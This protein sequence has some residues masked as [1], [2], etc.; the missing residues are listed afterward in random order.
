MGIIGRELNRGRRHLVHGTRGVKMS[1][2]VKRALISSTENE[3]RFEGTHVKSAKSRSGSALAH[4]E[5]NGREPNLPERKPSVSP[6]AIRV[7]DSLD[8]WL[9][10][11]S[12]EHSGLLVKRPRHWNAQMHEIDQVASSGIFGKGGDSERMSRSIANG[13]TEQL[14]GRIDAAIEDLLDNRELVKLPHSLR[15]QIHEDARS[16]GSVVRALCPSSPTIEV[17][18]EM[19]GENACKRWHQDHYIGRALVSYSGVM[20][21]QYTD[22]SNVDFW[23]LQNCGNNKCIIRDTDAV[24]SVEVGDILFIKGKSFPKGA[25]ALVHKAAELHYHEDG[26]IVNRLA[27]KVDVAA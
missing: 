8:D 21:T 14:L 24:R 4:L 22:D 26:R 6:S 19:I 17:K 9:Q 13:T 2:A 12:F 5:A 27:L 18:L 20:G 3:D 7:V 15:Q 1:S 11:Q 10:P 16:I 23:E 25:S